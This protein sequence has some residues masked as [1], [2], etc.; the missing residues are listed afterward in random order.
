MGKQRIKEGGMDIVK[1]VS[2]LTEGNIELHSMTTA[3]TGG[4]HEE[5]DEADSSSE[6]N[7]FD[8]QCMHRDLDGYVANDMVSEITTI[9]RDIDLATLQQQEQQRQSQSQW[10]HR[11]NVKAF[12]LSCLLFIICLLAVLLARK[13]NGHDDTTNGILTSKTRI[14]GTQQEEE[15]LKG[16]GEQLLSSNNG[17]TPRIIEFTVANLNTNAQNC[18][19][20]ENTHILQCIPSHNNSTNKFRIQ[21]HPT[22][23]PLGVERF[24]LLT[25]SNFWHDTRIFR[26]VNNF[27]S[28]WGISSY[29]EIQSGWEAMGPIQ[30]DP[31]V[32]SNDRGTV[33]FATS[34]PNTRTTQVF[35]NTH[36]N[37]Y[38]D[39]QGFA[40]IGKV[41]PAGDGYGGMEVVDEF[42]NGYGERPNQSRIS[43]E[44]SSYLVNEFP[45]LSY[46]VNAEF[47]EE[48]IFG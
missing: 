15:S 12:F 31:V 10:P 37:W 22:W 23:A 7:D 40:P 35:I 46:F 48:S 4:Y 25:T 28:Q 1:A 18:T 13:A 16:N 33:T 20:T 45:L 24:Q 5:D 32:A 29:P 43:E 11:R 38:L 47:V 17:G 19:H 26:I 21:L 2:P 30:D 34:G 39:S 41:L 8:I 3:A 14:Y 27:V 36:N 42:Y 9:S 44:G 6:Q